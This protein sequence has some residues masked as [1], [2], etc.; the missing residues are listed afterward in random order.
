MLLVFGLFV[1]WLVITLLFEASLSYGL[2]SPLWPNLAH[3]Q[4]LSVW[5]KY[6]DEFQIK[7]IMR[8][9]FAGISIYITHIITKDLKFTH[10]E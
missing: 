4:P 7:S 1:C 8:S 10:S 9:V 5:L 3:A 2:F 6:F